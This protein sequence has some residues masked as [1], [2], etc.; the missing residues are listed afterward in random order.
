MPALKILDTATPARTRVMR[1]APVRSAMNST[2]ST[3]RKAPRKAARGMR[4]TDWGSR[5]EH[6]ATISPAP[7]LTPMMFGA[8]RGLWRTL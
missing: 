3:P 6:S 5:A 2:S 8:A 7:E 4:V 1:L